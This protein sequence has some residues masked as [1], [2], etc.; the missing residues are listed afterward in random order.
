MWDWDAS[1]CAAM[2]WAPGPKECSGR[3]GI[4]WYPATKKGVTG[5]F[6]ALWKKEET[7]PKRK[8]A[9]WETEGRE[10]SI[11]ENYLKEG[12]HDD[13]LV[14]AGHDPV[15]EADK[16]EKELAEYRIEDLHFRPRRKKEKVKMDDEL[17][18]LEALEKKER[19]S[20]LH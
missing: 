2:L 15:K 17:K 8:N 10:K 7:V 4:L 11:W 18:R 13:A 12:R 20:K 9:Q 6:N 16:G 5:L 3:E 19:K 14:A 1:L